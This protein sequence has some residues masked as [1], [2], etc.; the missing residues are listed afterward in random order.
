MARMERVLREARTNVTDLVA[1]QSEWT[2]ELRATDSLL[3]RRAE[4][5]KTEDRELARLRT[6]RDEAIDAAEQL[7]AE[8]DSAKEGREEKEKAKDRAELLLSAAEEELVEAQAAL[9]AA[10]LR[11][12]DGKAALLSAKEDL[13]AAQRGLREVAT[14]QDRAG[15]AAADAATRLDGDEAKLK[16]RNEQRHAVQTELLSLGKKKAEIGEALEKT[17]ARLKTM[18]DKVTA[19]EKRIDEMR[20]KEEDLVARQNEL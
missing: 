9:E 4:D 1:T 10:Q 14:T 18:E 2:T 8:S 13:R 5:L 3:A 20:A 6:R 19:L 12:R 7:A 15:S 11:L 16:S 17:G